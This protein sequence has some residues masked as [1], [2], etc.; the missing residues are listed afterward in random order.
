MLDAFRY[1]LCSKLCQHNRR[2]PTSYSS[3]PGGILRN[4]LDLDSRA[5]LIPTRVI[6][7]CNSLPD[8]IINAPSISSFKEQLDYHWNI[9]M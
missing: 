6:N 2:V 9:F 8:Y 3:I 1:L 7:D 5:M 4:Y